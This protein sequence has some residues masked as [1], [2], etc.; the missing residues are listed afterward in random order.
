[1]EDI[2][3][4]YQ[5]PFDEAYPVI[6]MDEKPYQLLDET[7]APISM[8]PG[9]PEKQDCEYKRNGICSIFIFAEPLAGWRHTSVR[10]R[11]TRI[12]WANEIR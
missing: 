9:K 3:D 10:E 4:L 5:Q 11:R 1:M 8:K 7:R 2:L 12:D 6:C